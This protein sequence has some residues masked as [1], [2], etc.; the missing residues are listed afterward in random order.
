[1]IERVR[2]RISIAVLALT[3]LQANTTHGQWVQLGPTE[4]R[5]VTAINSDPERVPTVGLWMWSR[6]VL[7][8]TATFPNIEGAQLDASAYESM[9]VTLT[10]FLS[11]DLPGD[12]RIEVRHRYLAHPQIIHVMEIHA[13]PEEIEFTG[14]LEWDKDSTEAERMA[15]DNLWVPDLCFQ[16]MH[17]PAFQAY[18]PVIPRNSHDHAREF[19]T[20]VKRCF[21]FTEQGQT[22]LDQTTRNEF[23]STVGWEQD[24]P[25]NNPP[26]TQRHLGVWQESP[27]E[28]MK[29]VSPDRY[30]L[31]LMG[32]VSRDG[33]HLIALAGVSPEYMQQALFECLHCY[34]RWLPE[35]KPLMERRWRKKIYAMDNDPDRLLE[36]YHKDFGE[37]PVAAE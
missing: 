20:F 10:P 30:R 14:R 17:G 29:Y 36:R 18:S 34:G 21:I 19:Y 28:G 4:G 7:F 2:L 11:V 27:P 15:P 1:M 35:D 25:R 6:M 5:I 31:P 13:R 32:A 22:F 16:L 37:G 9:H 12:D 33:Q 26:I 3:V 23:A 8:V 24:D